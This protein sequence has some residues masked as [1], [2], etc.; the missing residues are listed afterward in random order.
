VAAAGTRLDR[1]MTGTLTPKARGPGWVRF[2]NRFL[3]ES[4]PGM[5]PNDALQEGACGAATIG[6][7]WIAREA[8]ANL[9]PGQVI[10]TNDKVGTTVTVSDVRPDA[11]T[12]SETGPLHRNDC[13]Y[14]T[15][16]GMLSAT[17]LVQQIGLAKITHSLRLTAQQ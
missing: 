13:T 4:L 1:A 10:E 6:G 5:P 17:T 15:K 8:L 2:T 9:R 3:F 12:I 11:V 14:D 16:T 7:L